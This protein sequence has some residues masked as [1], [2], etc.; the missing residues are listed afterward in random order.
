MNII[1]ADQTV[2]I[3]PAGKLDIDSAPFL[4]EKINSL[5]AQ[6]D[7]LWVVDLTHVEFIDSAGLGCLVMAVKTARQQ[8]CRLVLCNP[9]PAVKL[10][11]EITQLEKV[12][13]IYDSREA[14]LGCYSE[15]LTNQL[16]VA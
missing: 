13:T 5:P 16:L 14:A 10:I 8:N 4:K 6:K 2:I 11:L 3:Q 7:K 1:L 9:Q 15:S 12:L